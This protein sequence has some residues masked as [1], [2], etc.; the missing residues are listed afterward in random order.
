VQRNKGISKNRFKIEISIKILSYWVKFNVRKKKY[1]KSMS[2]REM[3][4]FCR[5][6][7]WKNYGALRFA[8]ICVYQKNVFD[9]KQFSLFLEA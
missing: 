2:L 8:K 1:K 9:E 3:L 6:W 7:T 5:G 4:I